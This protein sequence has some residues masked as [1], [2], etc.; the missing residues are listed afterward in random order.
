MPQ[1]PELYRSI[2][3]HVQQE[4]AGQD[5]TLVAF[6]PDREPALGSRADG[7]DASRIF[8]HVCDLWDAGMIDVLTGRDDTL[9]KDASG[10]PK[11]LFVAGLTD[12]GRAFLEAAAAH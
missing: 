3:E 5:R 11:Q 4:A 6:G 9:P 7:A 2:L 8:E 10:R 12:E 1:R